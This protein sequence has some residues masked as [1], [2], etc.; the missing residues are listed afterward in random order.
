MIIGVP[1][2]LIKSDPRAPL[3]PET[4]KSLCKLGA[5]LHI[6]SRCG[7]AIGFTDEDYATAGAKIIIDRGE[8][9]SN[10]DIIMRLHKPSTE[11]IAKL[12]KGSTHIS[13][14][15][16]FNDH[17]LLDSF[18]GAGVLSISM[19]MMPR[20]ARAQKMDALSSQASLA[21]YVAVIFAAEK[22]DRILPMM[23]TAAGTISPMKVFIIGVGVAGLQA[24][25]TAK[26]LGARVEA[27]D[28]RPVVAEQVKSLGAKF[29]DIDIG[30]SGETSAGYA[31]ALTDDQLEMQREGM[32]KIISQADI[33]ITTAQVF[34]RPAPLIVTGTMVKAMKSGSIIVD[35]G[36]ETGGNVEG[37]VFGEEVLTENGVTILG[38]GNLP[39]RVGKHASQMYSSNLL[40]FVSE[41]WDSEKK[42]LNLRSDDEIVKSCIITRGGELVNEIIIKN[43]Q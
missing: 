39:G 31:E 41:F 38:Q 4:V 2:E 30:D 14:F 6:E 35:M 28:T 23:M 33:V 3:I 21:G 11:E 5:D 1:K 40:N 42:K 18:I 25:A 26:R 22:I 37:S 17:K 16:P 43:R 10:A 34:G 7:E 20:I 13:F 27:F 15:D 24:I 12:K 19:E 8:V 36:V 9:L 32:K 29:V